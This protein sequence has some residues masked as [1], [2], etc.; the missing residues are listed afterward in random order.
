M[1]LTD[2]LFIMR[3]PTREQRCISNKTK[4]KKK[5]LL[6]DLG[7]KVSGCFQFLSKY[8]KKKRNGPTI[9]HQKKTYCIVFHAWLNND[10]EQEQLNNILL[11]FSSRLPSDKYSNSFFT[12]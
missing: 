12:A 5:A 3:F 10:H 7:V 8:K 4:Q 11:V 9:Q 6:D 1:K 2:T